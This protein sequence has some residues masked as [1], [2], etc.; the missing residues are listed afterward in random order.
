M[1]QQHEAPVSIT[2]ARSGRSD[3]IRRREIK[4]LVSMGVRTVCFVL[5]IVLHGPERWVL[6]A[7]A[8]VLPYFAVVIANAADSRQS[9][10]PPRFVSEELPRIGAEPSALPAPEPGAHD[11]GSHHPAARTDNQ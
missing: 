7:A 8:F 1:S 9:A 10:Q 4:Y 11:T 5:A 2:S 3:D 6:V